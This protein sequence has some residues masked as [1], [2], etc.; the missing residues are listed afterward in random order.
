M[1][2]MFL[3]APLFYFYTSPLFSQPRNE[4]NNSSK[5]NNNSLSAA[6]KM[7]V[8]NFSAT[9]FIGLGIDYSPTRHWF[10]ALNHKRISFTYN[11]GIAYYM[12]KKEIVSSY[13]YKYPGYLFIHGFGGLFYN[14][15]KNAGIT[16]TAGPALGIYNG[17]TEFNMGSK[18][19]LSYYINKQVAIGPGILLMKEPGT[20][21]LWAA[22]IKATLAFK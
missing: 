13:R 21:S 16:L 8:G 18:L 9:H 5:Q 15:V 6:L 12:G 7:P 22:M 19:E 4:I 20:A 14:P 1:K 10:G 11:G 2:K 3:V 17:T